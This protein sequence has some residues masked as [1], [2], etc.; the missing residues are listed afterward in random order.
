MIWFMQTDRQLDLFGGGGFVADEVTAPHRSRPLPPAGDLDDAGLI[1]AIPCASQ[2]TCLSLADEVARRR[3]AGA[4]PALTALCRRFR[5]FGL[6]RAVPEQVAAMRG[7]GAIGGREARAAITA[8]ITDGV[9]QGPGITVAVEVARGLRARLPAAVGLVLLRHSEPAVREHV[10]CCVQMTPDVAG[11]LL[12]LLGDL[13]RGV[14]DAAACALGRSGRVEAR[15]ALLRL[16]AER[17][18]AEAIEALA[19]VADETVIVLLGR[20]ARGGSALAGAALDALEDIDDIR[21]AA[22]VAGIKGR[23]AS[24]S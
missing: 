9:V 12:D 16:M 11:V 2:A 19:V 6:D 3:L 23:S 10:A 21:A 15:P 13:N 1:A 24:G 4:I 5:G 7:L 14:A 18:S 22:I 17:P 8:L 20:I